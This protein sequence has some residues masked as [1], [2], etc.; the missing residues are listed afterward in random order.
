MKTGVKY[1]SPSKIVKAMARLSSCLVLLKVD[2]DGLKKKNI[3]ENHQ[4]TVHH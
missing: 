3:A 1:H 2:P 4:R